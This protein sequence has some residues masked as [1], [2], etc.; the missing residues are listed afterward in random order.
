MPG[1]D[2]STALKIFSE[3]GRDINKWPTYKHFCSWLALC[4]GTRI[5]GGRIISGRTKAC[6]NK[7]G[8]A[9][10]MAANC[11]YKSQTMYGSYLR[12]MKSRMAPAQAVTALANK[13]ARTIYF[14]IRNKEPY[15]EQGADY[16]DKM[17][18]EKTLKFLKK[19]AASIGFKL[20]KEETQVSSFP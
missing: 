7:A 18:G 20:V 9:L 11:L 15:R 13:M 6:K 1:I 14:M 10:R 16:Y 5:S 8:V 4:P 3:I 12:K 2:A 17:N 19:R